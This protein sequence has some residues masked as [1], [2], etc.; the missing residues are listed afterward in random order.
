M[1]Y[2]VLA[3]KYRPQTFGQVV[4]QEHVT[5]T[6]QN[7]LEQKRIHHAYLF[8][9]SRG[10]G[11]TT[12]ARLFAK[13]LHCEKGG[14]REPCNQCAVCQEITEGHNLDVQEIDGASNTSVDDVR[15]IREQVKYLPTKGHYRIYIIDEVHMLS[16]SAFN[17]LL[18]TLEEPP[19]HVLFIFAT[20]EWQKI[21]ATI[22]S[23]CQRYDFKRIPT[24]DIVESLKAIADKEGVQ[25]VE[26]AMHLLARESEGSLRDAE[27][28]FDQ[29]IAFAG[30]TVSTQHLQKMFGFLDRGQVFALLES[31]TN[32]ETQKSLQLLQQVF[33]TGADLNRLAMDLLEGFRVLLLLRTAA[34]SAADLDLSE[35]EWSRFKT[36]AATRTMVEWDQIFQLAYAGLEDVLQGSSPKMILEVLLVRM[37]HVDAFVP[38]ETLVEKTTTVS[39]RPAAI[40]QAS[41]PVLA[42]APAPKQDWEAF[43]G[44]ASKIKPQ[45]ASIFQHGRFVSFEGSQILFT[46]DSKEKVYSEMLEEPERK[47]QIRLLLKEFFKKQMDVKLVGG[48]QTMPQAVPARKA[49][50]QKQQVEQALSHESVQA[51]ADVF[52]ARVEEVRPLTKE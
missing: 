23:R 43:L 7:A 14:G 31:I 39:P 29:A 18:K 49:D 38:V 47:D 48:G 30:K 40:L 24:A 5:V 9:G 51:A 6:L 8:S 21:P 36:L 45:V 15:E 4:G 25:I 11:K 27:S 2:Q 20:T 17:A 33:Q 52:G 26:E 12:V 41:T 42:S 37:T 28:L 10:I 3:R 35:A 16:T 32:K 34:L 50:L 1:S 44:W 19:P 22:L 46:F 13:A